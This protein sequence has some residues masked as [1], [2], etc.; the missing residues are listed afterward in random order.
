[1]MY[2]GLNVSAVVSANV[3]MYSVYMFACVYVVCLCVHTIV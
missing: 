3:H 2:A 1:M